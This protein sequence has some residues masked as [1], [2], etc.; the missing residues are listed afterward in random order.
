VSGSDLFV[1]NNAGNTVTEMDAS[2]GAYVNMIAGAA[3]RFD[4]PTAIIAVGS[5]LFVANGTG[6]TVTEFAATGGTLVRVMRGAR[7]GFSDPLA[8]AAWGNHLFVLNGT[9]SVTEVGINEGSVLGTASGSQFGFD[10]P[11]AM[12]LAGP[13]LLFVVN[14]AGNSV[15]EIATHTLGLVGVRPG[16]P[17]NSPRRPA[18]PTTGGTCGCPTRAVLR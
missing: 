5:N 11:T 17:T 13:N 8:L 3:Y 1:A 9:G 7:Y 16:R 12:A 18:S 4:G 2:S 15:T 6:N 14:S 10:A